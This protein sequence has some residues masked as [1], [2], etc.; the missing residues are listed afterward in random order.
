MI[1]RN[2]HEVVYSGYSGV[3]VNSGSPVRLSE[4]GD[5]LR[6]GRIGHRG[7]KERTD[8]LRDQ[9][10]LA[11]VQAAGHDVRDHER[12]SDSGVIRRSS[13]VSATGVAIWT[14]PIDYSDTADR[15]YRALLIGRSNDAALL[16]LGKRFA[17]LSAIMVMISLVLV[18]A[19][20]F[21]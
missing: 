7:V 4:S 3:A 11:L 1:N 14:L 17:M 15:Q 6:I 5:T 19:W 9:E 8:P 20:R 16:T 10:A 2:A 12:A 13:V 21:S 18:L